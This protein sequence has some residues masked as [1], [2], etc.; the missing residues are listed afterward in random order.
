MYSKMKKE[1][2]AAAVVS[3]NGSLNGSQNGLS[4]SMA[5]L[6]LD[7]AE[8]AKA[9]LPDPTADENGGEENDVKV[10][11]KRG[12][13][14]ATF[15]RVGK[16]MVDYV[17]DYLENIGDRPVLPNVQPGYLRDLL[18]GAA[19]ERPEDFEKVMEDVESKIMPGITHWNH[20]NFH[21]Y[22]PSLNSYP[23]ILGDLLSSAIGCVGFSWIASPAATEL[24]VIVCDWMVKAMDLPSHFLSTS[25]TGGAV[26]HGT[27]TE[28][29]LTC[30]LAARER[31]IKD[32][33]KE[34]PESG[35]FDAFSRLV[36]YSTDQT[37]SM[38]VRNASF[39]GIEIRR[40]HLPEGRTSLNRKEFVQAVEEDK[41]KGRIPFFV[42]GSFGTTSSCDFDPVEEIGPVCMS[43]RIW[44][45][46][47]AAYAGAFLFCPEYRPLMRGIEYADSFNFNPHK[48]M[49]VNFDCSALFLRCVEDLF[50]G[51]KEDLL[52]GLKLMKIF[53]EQGIPDYRHWEIPLGRRFRALKIWFVLRSMG[54]QGLR[55]SLRHH[56]QMADHFAERMGADP[57]F[58]VLTKSL[59]LVT[60]RVKDTDAVNALL[61][62]LICDDG[63]IHLNAAE[64]GNPPTYYL[65][66]VCTSHAEQKD[67]DFAFDVIKS[68]TARLRSRRLSL[69]EVQAEREKML[70]NLAQQRRITSTG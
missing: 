24:E 1:A 10:D 61:Y 11:I 43:E 7:S 27:A 45:H 69:S 42:C 3:Q 34:H 22:Y 62:N 41:A 55:K 29:T 56:V 35:Y 5:A 47:D 26:I 21:A 6:G 48:M 30:M 38:I 14:T 50:D 49:H 25:E 67:V 54:L 46:I 64:T 51:L 13:D 15:R 65:R 19:P 52:S 4:H 33:L 23:S 57:E 63:R 70:N 31:A 28:S 2:A 58:E 53:K 66:F 37:H 17:A 8:S 16:Q 36:C 18:P 60:F 20:P 44:L 40:L 12:M 68:L 59:G 39:I 32:W 9:A